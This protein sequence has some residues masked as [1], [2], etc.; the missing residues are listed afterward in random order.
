MSYCVL[1]LARLNNDDLNELILKNIDF[2]TFV[3]WCYCAYKQVTCHLRQRSVR[4]TGGQILF[5]VL[6]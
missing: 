3:I 4:Y 5:F 1:T 6:V 2:F